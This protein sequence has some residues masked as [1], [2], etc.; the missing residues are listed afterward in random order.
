MNYLLKLTT[1]LKI[2]TVVFAGLTAASS[3]A[4]EL[5]SN[6]VY[7]IDGDTIAIEFQKIR[8]WGL[9]TPELDE[10]AGQ[11]AK[12]GLMAYLKNQE[13]VCYLQEQKSHDRTIG[14]CFRGDEDIAASVV[15]AGFGRDCP[16]YSRGLYAAFETTGHH[17]MILP[18]YCY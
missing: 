14:M 17:K 8:L 16:R 15:Q 13:V 18:S 12:N 4:Q 3:Y 9:H 11:D 5:K 7:V 2:S 10:K 6:D 1:Y